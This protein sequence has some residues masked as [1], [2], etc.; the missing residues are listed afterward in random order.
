MTAGGCLL[1]EFN[2]CIEE[3]MGSG[4]KPGGGGRNEEGIVLDANVVLKLR[5]MVL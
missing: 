2:D 5:L 4:L 1:R 3:G